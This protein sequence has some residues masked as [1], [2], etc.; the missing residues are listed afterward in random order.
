MD[1]N[2]TPPAAGGNGDLAVAITARRGTFKLT[3]NHVFPAGT[4]TAIIGANGS[5]KTTL[6]EAIAGVGGLVEGKIHRGDEKLLDTTVKPKQK[7]PT[8]RRSTTLLKQSPALFPTLTVMENLKFGPRVQKKGPQETALVTEKIADLLDL[9][10]FKDRYPHELS[11]GQRGRVALGRAFAAQPKTLLLDEPTS[12]FDVKAARSF[13]RVLHG[14]FVGAE[15]KA[16]SR[17]GITHAAPDSSHVVT[18]LV[19][20]TIEDVL[21]LADFVIVLNNGEI[22]ESGPADTVLSQPRHP[23]TAEFAG[24][25]RL[26]AK[27]VTTDATE[28]TAKTARGGTATVV[29]E[30]GLSFVGDFQKQCA[31]NPGADVFVA[32]KPSRIKIGT[33]SPPSAA[34]NTWVTTVLEADASGSGYALTLA[35]PPGTVVQIDADEQRSKQFEPGDA[36]QVTV[37]SADVV[38]YA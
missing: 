24:I 18:I 29:F 20:H 33:A 3:F 8:Y 23:F 4:V 21:S 26:L 13:R 34:E 17:P 16:G 6:V 22:V 32:I 1:S 15:R 9:A 28:A 36:V 30:D 35:S 27:F 12:A 2:A 25:N 38:I 5:G 7:V 31:Q 11:G 10:E 19:T 37:S 14:L